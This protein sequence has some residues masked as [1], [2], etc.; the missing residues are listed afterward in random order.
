MVFKRDYFIISFVFFMILILFCCSSEDNK[1]KISKSSDYS[2]LVSLFGDFRKFQEPKLKNGVPDYTMSAMEEQRRGITKFQERLAA[3]NISEWP[4]SQ[5]VDYHLV[6]AEMNGIDFYH[7][8]LQ[9]WTRDPD[10]YATRNFGMRRMPTLPL[11][12]D[13]IDGYRIKLQAVPEI[14]KQAKDNIN[15]SKA[16]GDTALLAIESMKDESAF[17][18]G[19]A[20]QLAEYHP[21]LVPDAERA[22]AAVEDYSKWIDDNK[23]RMI[24]SVGVGKE[25]YNWWLKNVWLLPYTWEECWAI[26]QR[27]YE[28][29]VCLLK[30]EENKNRKIPQLEPVNTEQE[31]N[32]R[33]KEVEQHVLEFVQEEEI[34]TVPDFLVPIGPRPYP[35]WAS[36]PGRKE[37]VYPFFLQ[38]A[39]RDPMMEII[40][41]TLGHNFDRL[42]GLY[43]NRPVRGTRRLY[44]ISRIRSEA[45]AFGLEEMLM[46]AGILDENPR[47]REVIEIATAYRA[48]RA[49]ADLKMHS[50]EFTFDEAC[51]FEAD[52][53][54]RGWATK[55]SFTMWSH[56]RGTPRLPGNE[57]GYLLGKV[58][59]EK[60]LADRTMQLRD[61]FDLS[62][63]MDEFLAAG[64]IPISLI[65]WEMTGFDDEIKRLW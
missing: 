33:W 46:H 42:R 9:P 53:C 45:V 29:I 56:K 26:A 18:G 15:L 49:M 30:V 8:V 20:M 38:V 16:K 4:I 65:R 48:L 27:E 1:A 28:R 63:F 60:A 5:Q 59:F 31:F 57:M 40:H 44:G 61:K 47:G 21:D 39:D 37:A 22:K 24:A 13:K 2:V 32:L 52:K 10:F 36:H 62:Q 17:Y 14:L 11:Q 58:Q 12:K 35:T 43:D 55:N 3:I 34:F 51:Q 25:N 41:N 19:L 6:R 7:R 64:M 23:G 54:P 50:N